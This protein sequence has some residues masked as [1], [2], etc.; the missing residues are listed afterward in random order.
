ACAPLACS[1]NGSRATTYGS[2]PGPA[3]SQ[4][5]WIASRAPSR[6]AGAFPSGRNSR[7]WASTQGA[8]AF[9]ASIDLATATAALR[10][11]DASPASPRHPQCSARLWS[12][13]PSPRAAISSAD[14]MLEAEALTP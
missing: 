5:A 14:I 2:P 4:M 12:R 11:A 1:T 3:S 13:S 9:E 7:S 10:R 8:S 6:A